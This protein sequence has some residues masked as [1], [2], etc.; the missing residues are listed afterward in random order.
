MCTTREEGPVILR[1]PPLTKLHTHPCLPLQHG[2]CRFLVQKWGIIP[3]PSPLTSP[4]QCQ[5]QSCVQI[6]KL[7]PRGLVRRA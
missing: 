4:T 1:A 5:S 3:Y 7:R 2:F 6:E